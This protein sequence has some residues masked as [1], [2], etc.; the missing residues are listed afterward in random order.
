M[1]VGTRPEAIK[2]APVMR[3]MLGDP[4]TF[5]PI[6]IATAQHREMLDQVLTVFDLTPDVDLDLMTPGQKLP[7]LTARSIASLATVLRRIRPDAVLVQGD[8]TT[9][10][11]GALAAFYERIPSGHV[12]AGLRTYNLDA[13]WP[14]ELNRRLISPMARWSFA[15]VESSRENLLAER[16]PADRIFVT[17]NTVIDALFQV[18]EKV[19]REPPRI[20]GLEPGCL[21]GKKCILVTGH[22]RESHGD[23]LRAICRALLDV[24]DGHP[25][26]AIVY[27]VHP[28]PD[29]HGCVHEIL[30]SHPGVHLMD[31]LAYPELVS[32]L[33]SCYCV[34]TDSGGLQE[35]APALGK[36]VLVTRETTE[37]PEVV[38]AG[39]AKLVGSDRGLIVGSVETLLTDRAVYSEMSR[40]GSPYGDGKAAGRILRVLQEHE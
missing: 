26:I 10:F 19:D 8:T 16:V 12:E 21:D 11:A 4:G 5:E 30:G 36:P 33:K 14:E 34:I 17:G 28:N 7:D 29:V 31:P 24:A 13:P 2:M 6:L 18:A 32:L 27:P 3:A 15:P 40:G 1:I 22:R 9:A 35:E 39:M 38:E 37:R 23:P 20:H 25:E